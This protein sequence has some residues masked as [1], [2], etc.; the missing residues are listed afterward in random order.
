MLRIRL[1]QDEVRHLIA[2]MQTDRG[3]DDDLLLKEHADEFE[4]WWLQ[5]PGSSTASMERAL[6]EG[7]LPYRQVLLAHLVSMHLH[8]TP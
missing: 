6:N 7:L 3:Q 4:E 8:D 1:T 2:R 5:D